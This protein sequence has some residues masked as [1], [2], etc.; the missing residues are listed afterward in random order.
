M[1]KA[2]QLTCILLLVCLLVVTAACSVVNIDGGGKNGASLLNL[3]KLLGYTSKYS[4]NTVT[5][6]GYSVNVSPDESV[7]VTVS[8]GDGRKLISKATIT[9]I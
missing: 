5:V 7:W 9:S 6:D 4:P 8:L 2:R 3:S 1:K